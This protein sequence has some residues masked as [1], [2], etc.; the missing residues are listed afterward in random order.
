MWERR[1]RQDWSVRRPPKEFFIEAASGLL[2]CDRCENSSFSTL[3]VDSGRSI[4]WD[5]CCAPGRSDAF[6]ASFRNGRSWRNLSVQGRFCASSSAKSGHFGLALS[7]LAELGF[8]VF[9]EIVHV[10]VA[11]GLEPVLMGFDGEGS[12]EATAGG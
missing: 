8:L 6:E 1:T 12:D 5:E 10:E 7:G 9:L 11:V 2:N 3:S 4:A